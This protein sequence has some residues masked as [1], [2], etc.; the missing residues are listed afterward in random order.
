MKLVQP[1][2]K[3]GEGKTEPAGTGRTYREPRERGQE[4]PGWALARR[5]YSAK[6]AFSTTNAR[7][8]SARRRE[9]APAKEGNSAGG[10][11][12]QSRPWCFMN[13]CEKFIIRI[14]PVT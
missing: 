14:Y 13:N 6:V 8:D 12:Q 9:A 7:S 1:C 10:I 11:F 2:P 4:A 5:A 3:P